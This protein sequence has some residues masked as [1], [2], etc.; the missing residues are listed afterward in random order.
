MDPGEGSKNARASAPAALARA[1]TCDTTGRQQ[2]TSPLTWEITGYESAERQH[3]TSPGKRQH[4]TSPATW[5]TT[6]NESAR[7]QLASPT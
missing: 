4:V 7:Q 5:E 2:V 6:G 1:A 3:V